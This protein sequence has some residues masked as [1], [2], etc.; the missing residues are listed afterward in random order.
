MNVRCDHCGEELVDGAL[1]CGSCGAATPSHPAHAVTSQMGATS[2]S[3]TSPTTRF[4][5]I[6]GRPHPAGVETTSFDPD[7]P[8]SDE[9]SADRSPMVIAAVAL[10][11]V[12]LVVAAVG[13]GLWATSGD[14]DA[15][16]QRSDNGSGI[17]DL[18]K[19]GEVL[20]DFAASQTTT[21]VPD[22][23]AAPT[24]VEATTAETTESTVP[25]TTVAPTTVA[26]TTVAPTTLP[27]TTV[28]PTTL[29]PTTVPPPTTVVVDPNAQAL[30]ELNGLIASD[31]PGVSD[32]AERWVPQLSAKRLGIEWQGVTYGYPEILGEHLALRAATGAVLVDGSTYNFR[33]DN[34]PMVGW[35]ISIVPIGFDTAE[36][37]LNWCAQR[38]F[39]RNNCAAKFIST[40]IALSGTL[41][42]QPT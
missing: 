36:G 9:R 16:D 2:P 22:D 38:G 1:F 6:D 40:N 25:P 31:A 11:A 27:P 15:G 14:R 23:T 17:D 19:P 20:D 12:A 34:N 39:D 35:Y 32:V 29:P 5:S 33:I 26:P 7:D 30:N 24:S 13:L 18:A 42:L 21:V 28:P 3:A 41:R 10:A 37:A 4:D 8:P